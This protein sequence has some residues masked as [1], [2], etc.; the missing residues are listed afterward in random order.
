M[1]ATAKQVCLLRG[2][3]VEAFKRADARDGVICDIARFTGGLFDFVMECLDNLAQKD[4][5][6]KSLSQMLAI[7]TNADSPSGK[8]PNGYEK[9]KVFLVL[10]RAFEAAKET[11][12]GNTEDGTE[13]ADGTS[14]E[15]SEVSP[16]VQ[17][18]PCGG[19][20]GHKG[21]SHSVKS[22]RHVYGRDVRRVWPYGSGSVPSHQQTRSRFQKD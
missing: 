18:K 22:H 10:S 2:E 5:T 20:L 19:R 9:A 17:P 15:S 14:G 13:E 6:I 21:V 12:G 3:L 4:N 11:A 7:Y 1:N 8:D 16:T